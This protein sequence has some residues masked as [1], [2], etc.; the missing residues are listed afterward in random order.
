VTSF[1]DVEMSLL[2]TML[3]ALNSHRLT[4]ATSAAA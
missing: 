2:A 1:K 4:S 3:Q